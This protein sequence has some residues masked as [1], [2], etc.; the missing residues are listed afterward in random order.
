MFVRR[1]DSGAELQG[2]ADYKFRVGVAIPLLEPRPD[3]L[4]TKEEMETLLRIEDALSDRLQR[5]Q[6]SLQV[7]SITTN[8]MREFIFYTRSPSIVPTAVQGVQ[9]QFPSHHVQHYVQEDRKW[10]VYRQFTSS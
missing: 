6:A 7:L 9:A 4:P 3:G 5:N 8:G 2:H 1:N 10:T